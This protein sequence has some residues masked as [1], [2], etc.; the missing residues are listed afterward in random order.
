[1]ALLGTVTTDTYPKEGVTITRVFHV[2]IT[3]GA[4][5]FIG[6][7][8]GLAAAK[9]NAQAVCTAQTAVYTARLA[10]IDN[11]LTA[12]AGAAS[13]TADT[14][15]DEM[16]A[17]IDIRQNTFTA[18]SETII[19]TEGF[20]GDKTASVSLTRTIAEIT[21]QRVDVAEAETYWGT[22]LYNAIGAL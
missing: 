4:K 22:D 8:A 5:S 19:I 20:E 1:M 21:D 15:T 16:G 3:G 2:P 14:T 6:E 13:A 7:G 9:T 10:Y 11:W 12:F 18:N 17:T